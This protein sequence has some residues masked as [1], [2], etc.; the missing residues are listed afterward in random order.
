MSNGID[1]ESPEAEKDDQKEDQDE[2]PKV[3]PKGSTGDPP[4]PPPDD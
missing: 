1:R 4:K 2:A 3:E